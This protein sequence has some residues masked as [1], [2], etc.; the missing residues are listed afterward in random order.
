MSPCHRVLATW[1][2]QFRLVWMTFHSIMHAWPNSVCQEAVLSLVAIL[3][4]QRAFLESV[5]EQS[6]ASL[7]FSFKLKLGYGG[8]I[9]TSNLQVD[10]SS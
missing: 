2:K 4:C 8:L 1:E 9:A 3:P 6:F 10:S 5:V 7:D